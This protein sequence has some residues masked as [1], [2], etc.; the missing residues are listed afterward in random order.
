M[1]RKITGFYNLIPVRKGFKLQLGDA[2]QAIELMK[3]SK[4]RFLAIPRTPKELIKDSRRWYFVINKAGEKI[5]TISI[6]PSTGEIG[7]F[8]ILPE[9]R[10]AFDANNALK[11]AEII[12]SN[13]GHKKAKT[14]VNITDPRKLK[15]LKYLKWQETGKKIKGR[16]YGVLY[17]LIELEKELI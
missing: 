2:F 7:G 10:T 15:A 6:R 4:N 17:N 3:K 14:Y 16:K 12:L 5:G 11:T 8:S 13:L 1:K 9:H